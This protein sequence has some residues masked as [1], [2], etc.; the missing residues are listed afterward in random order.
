MNF[1]DP[2][3]TYED[4]TPY[5]AAQYR[6]IIEEQVMISYLS[7]SISFFDTDMISPHDR[8]IILNTLRDIKNYEKKSIEDAFKTN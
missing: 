4:G 1:F 8:K 3:W 5:K 6:S 7:Q 2:N